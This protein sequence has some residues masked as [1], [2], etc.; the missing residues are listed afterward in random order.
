MYFGLINLEYTEKNSLGEINE[1]EE[2]Y[3]DKIWIKFSAF[4]NSLYT[5]V[6][7]DVGKMVC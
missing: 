5:Y 7:V 4:I 2:E 3:T 6:Y 1:R